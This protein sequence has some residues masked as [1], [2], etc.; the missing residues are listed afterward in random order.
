MN[1]T[2]TTLLEQHPRRS[3]SGVL[4]SKRR[5]E[6]K[7]IE[8]KTSYRRLM[9]SSDI[10]DA[11]K[12]ELRRRKDGLDLQQ[13]LEATHALQSKLISMVQPWI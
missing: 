11:E 6:A 4:I 10:S 9:E 13:L 12:N 1:P 5:V 7:V 3:A 8:A 2:A